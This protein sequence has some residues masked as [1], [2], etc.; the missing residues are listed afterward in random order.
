MWFLVFANIDNNLKTYNIYYNFFC[1]LFNR[2]KFNRL[3]KD[4]GKAIY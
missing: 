1:I 4:G 3:E 2:L